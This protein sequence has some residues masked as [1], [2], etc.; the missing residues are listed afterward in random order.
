MSEK[1]RKIEITPGMKLRVGELIGLVVTLACLLL[2]LLYK[3]RMAVVIP[4]AVAAAAGMVC[5][6]VLAVKCS[7]MERAQRKAEKEAEKAQKEAEKEAE[8][9]K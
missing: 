3:D 7:M 2:I 5:Y 6:I 1:K 8:Q 4:L 9:Q